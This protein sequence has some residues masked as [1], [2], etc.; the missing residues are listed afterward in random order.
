MAT[1]HVDLLGDRL[2]REALEGMARQTKDW[3]IPYMYNHDIRYPPLG[4]AVSAELIQLQDGEYGLQLTTQIFE[5]SDSPQSLTGDGRRMVVREGEIET[6]GILYDR[7]F[8]D[9]AGLD[10]LD[11]LAA[12]LPPQGEPREYEKKGLE[13]VGT[14]T[15]LA[16]TFVVGAIAKGFFSKL[17]SDAYEKL[18]KAFISY[19][20]KK[21]PSEQV[22]DFC[23]LI[24]EDGNPLEIHVLLV[25]PSEQSVRQLFALKFDS[26][27]DTLRSLP[28]AETDVARIVFEFE[29]HRLVLRHA[30]RSDCVPLAFARPE[31]E[32]PDA[33]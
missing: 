31:E 6:I 27:D 33:S 20:R 22:L 28:L 11:E 4:R 16:G 25:N 2:T 9:K 18:K 23:F 10:L 24:R 12:L 5:P 8:R 21:V 7:T 32:Q 13:L 26:L 29:E 1:S 14:L 19:Y 15:I 30:V 17:G 3:Y